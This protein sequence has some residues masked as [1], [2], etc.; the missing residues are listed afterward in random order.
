[1]VG[2][3]GHNASKAFKREARVEVQLK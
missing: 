2:G 3:K 1:V